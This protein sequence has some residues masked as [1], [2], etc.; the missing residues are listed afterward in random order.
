VA[1]RNYTETYYSW[2]AKARKTLEIYNWVLG[3]QEEK[4]DFWHQPNASFST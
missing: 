3:R 1:A 2:D 4:P